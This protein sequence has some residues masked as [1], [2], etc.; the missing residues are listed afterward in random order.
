M[1]SYTS[2]DYEEG[3][4]P[5]TPKS[6]EVECATKALAIALALLA[7]L[8]SVTQ[9]GINTSLRERAVPIPFMAACVN[10][11]VGLI[12]IALVAL[13]TPPP[14]SMTTSLRKAPWYAHFR[15]ESMDQF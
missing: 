15:I 12:F 14:S 13:A 9:S 5:P 2:H 7:G 11:V 4:E 8:S 3:T 6:D 10:F 1:A